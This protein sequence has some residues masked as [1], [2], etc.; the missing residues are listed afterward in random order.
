V[1]N[2]VTKS[3]ANAFHGTAWEYLRNSVFD[4][5]N[6]FFETVSPLRQN[7]FGANGGEPVPLPR[8]NGRNR[9]FFFVSYEGFRN[10]TPSQTLGRIPTA[11]ELTGALGDLGVP[12]YNPFSTR[13]DPANAGQFLRDPFPGGANFGRVLSIANTPRQLQFALKLRF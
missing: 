9:T 6:P 7:Q 12:I 3:G 1:I 13:P 10:R 2:V 5:R 11:N 8:Y 4:A